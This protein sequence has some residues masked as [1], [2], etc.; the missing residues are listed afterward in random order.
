MGNSS[1]IGPS[2]K[3]KIIKKKGDENVQKQLTEKKLS[4]ADTD[5]AKKINASTKSTDEQ[6]VK[7]PAATMNNKVKSDANKGSVKP[8][9]SGETKKKKLIRKEKGGRRTRMSGSNTRSTSIQL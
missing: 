8:K 4:N 9:I 6:F 2:V 3:K 5:V 1:G 7:K